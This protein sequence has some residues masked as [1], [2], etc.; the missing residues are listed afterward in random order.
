MTLLYFYSII[1][2]NILLR[3][4]DYML[5]AFTPISVSQYPRNISTNCLAFSLG[6]TKE[7]PESS[8]LYNLDANYTIETAF[9]KKVLDLVFTKPRHINSVHD[10]QPEEYAFMVFDFTPYIIWNPFLGNMTFWDFHV[11]RRE[12]DG[13]WV[14]KPGWHDTPEV[15]NDW[16]A[17]HKEFGNK[18]VLFALAPKK[19][20]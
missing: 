14:H 10:L 15:V 18:I 16:K 2:Y 7:I 3:G 13:T 4:D 11:I 1:K 20:G 5:K 12:L 9:E 17:I 19:G 6:I 8:D